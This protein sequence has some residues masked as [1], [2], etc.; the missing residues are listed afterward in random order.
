MKTYYPRNDCLQEIAKSLQSNSNRR[1]PWEDYQKEAM[2]NLALKTETDFEKPSANTDKLYMNIGNKEVIEVAHPTAGNSAE[3]T[4][5]SL[6]SMR[7]HLGAIGSGRDFIKSDNLRN[8]FAKNHNLLATDVELSSVLDSIIGNCR[9]SFILVKGISDY[10]DGMSTRKW[11][12][13]ASLSAAS[14]VKSIICG[15][16]APTNV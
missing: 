7:V 2:K 16:D 13:Y 15:M 5:D 9:D 4:T 14:V 3:D 12:N 6:P 8:D 10:K 1:R 11:Q